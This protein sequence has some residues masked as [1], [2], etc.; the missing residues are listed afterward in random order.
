MAQFLTVHNALIF[1]YIHSK[2]TSL[3]WNVSIVCVYCIYIYIFIYIVKPITV[4]YIQREKDTPVHCAAYH[5]QN[6]ILSLLI[7]H[8]GDVNIQNLVS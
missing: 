1:A 5:G 6:K 8:G 4:C 3:H 7:A 2:L